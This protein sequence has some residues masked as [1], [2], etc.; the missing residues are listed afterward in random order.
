MTRLLAIIGFLLASNLTA[1]PLTVVTDEWKG[2]TSQDGKGYYMDLLR[3]VY[4]QPTDI[5]N[6]SVVP[7]ARSLALVKSGKADIVLGIYL[8]DIPKKHA[9]AYVVEQDLVDVLL[10]IETAKSW[11]GM[12][13]LE[14]KVVLARISYAYD[15]LTDVKM[16]YSERASLVSMLKMIAVG[17]A[18]AILDYKA[19][20]EPMMKQAGLAED[21]FSIL[22][23]VLSAP[24]YFGFADTPKGIAAKIRFEKRF[25]TLYKSGEIKKMM[26]SNLG[27]SKGLP[28]TLQSWK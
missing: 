21:K 8:G 3:A 28:K 14:G 16:H 11:E 18:D 2:Y 6:F 26:E 5:I 25:K 4:N 22:R 7:Y 23:S 17:R 20:L 27:H 24:V 9:A 15:A 19:D 1:E 13:T 10:P 12:K